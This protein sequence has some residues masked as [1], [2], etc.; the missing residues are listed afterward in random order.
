MPPQ[1]VPVGE[2]GPDINQPANQTTHPGSEP[3]QIGVTGNNLQDDT[4][5]SP[6]R[7]HQ[8]LDKLSVRM[9]DMGTNTS[10]VE[11]RPNRD[12]TRASTSNANAQTSL[13]IV[14]VMLPSQQ[15][16]QIAMTQINL[17]ILGYEPESLRNSHIR[18]PDT[19]AQESLVIPQLDGP[20]SLLSKRS[21]QKKNARRY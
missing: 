4:F 6:P 13:P 12:G 19:R 1:S 15:G 14:D 10:D 20:V 21:Y 3:T 16:D 11:V 17:S 7:T 5:V 9:V 2:T 18:S 8:Q